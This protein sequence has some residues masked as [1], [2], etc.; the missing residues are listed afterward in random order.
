[1]K[2]YGVI[3]VIIILMIMTLLILIYIPKLSHIEFYETNE[4]VYFYNH[5]DE[6][7]KIILKTSTL[8]GEKYYLIEKEQG[9]GFI[10][11]LEIKKKANYIATDSDATLIIYFK[12]GT[13]KEFD[14][15][16]GNFKY[17]NERYEM[18]NNLYNLISNNEIEYIEFSK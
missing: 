5:K 14:F 9:I 1:M 2:K 6:I 10:E 17:E 7:E 11:N 3:L 12:T 4:Y 8:I 15:E 13:K 16:A 18:N